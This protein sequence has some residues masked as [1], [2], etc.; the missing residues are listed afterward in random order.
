MDT[1]TP[2]SVT[3]GQAAPD[4]TLPTTGGR[5]VTLSSLRGH[6]VVLYFYPADDT[7]GCTTQAC[8]L[9][10]MYTQITGS[11]AVVLGVSP[12]DVESHGRFATKFGLP[13][14]LLSDPDHTVS[15]EY[16]T[17]KE[18]EAYGKQFWGIERST[19][20]IAPDGTV[21]HAWRRVKPVGH[22]DRV[23]EALR[24]METEAPAPA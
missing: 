1:E 9:R 21:R 15:T 12:D 6:P 2:E 24:E 18:R 10:D 3:E 22:A 5:E 23:L 13:F 20:I 8:D 14:T 17:W 4:F 7:P 19:F 16:G 11:N